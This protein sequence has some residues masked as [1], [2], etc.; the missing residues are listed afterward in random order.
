MLDVVDRFPLY[1]LIVTFIL[2]PP[3]AWLVLN[4]VR[5][6]FRIQSFT[7]LNIF[8]AGLLCWLSGA[9]GIRFKDAFA[10]SKLPLLF[11]SLYVGFALLNFFLLR[12]C[13]RYGTLWPT[14][15]FLVPIIFLAYI[16]YASDMLNP[17]ASLLTSVGLTRF[18]I[19]FIGISYLSFRLVHLV[20]EVR[21]EV[22]EMPTI[23]EYLAFAFF[24]PTISIGP[25]NPY[26]NFI[27][28]FRS[29]DRSAT[30]I[31]RSLL[32]ILVGFTKYI[33]LGS[34]AA[35]FTYAGLLRD[36]HPHAMI[37]LIIAIPAYALYL[38]CNFSGF[39][40]MVIGVSGLLNI[41]VAEN[42]D[43]PFLARNLQEFWTRWHITLSTW[44][45]DIMFTPL[46]KTMMRRFGPKAANHVIAASI[47]ISFL[48]VGIWHG[49]G[50]H[51]LIFGATQGV[52]IAAV[53]YYTVWLK[54]RLGRDRFAAYRKNKVIRAVGTVVTFA[55]FSL[56]L[57]VFAN[58]WSDVRAIHAH[59]R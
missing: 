14:A 51:F 27:G 56:S 58:T 7:S 52:G 38:Y 11:F 26:S 32:R 34:L 48:V 20:Q 42:F 54:K 12:Y 2:Y 4:H 50:L 8:G 19:F 36:G 31:G 30:P 29:P 25:I 3:V 28:S 22:V 59:L 6:R 18:G 41:Q 53:H 40:D 33:F 5:P 46:T 21:N 16:K 24:V 37:D 57:F 35:Q 47:L 23:W 13:R 10:Y 44:I 39:C 15:A 43:R 9:A 55:Y 49:K 45:R 1:P 17:F